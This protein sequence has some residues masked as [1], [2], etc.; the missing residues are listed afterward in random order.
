M[1]ADRWVLDGVAQ[2]SSFSVYHFRGEQL[3]AVS[4]VN[5]PKEHLQARKRLDEGRH[6]PT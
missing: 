6:T 5:A 1:E 4:S 3:V 2:S